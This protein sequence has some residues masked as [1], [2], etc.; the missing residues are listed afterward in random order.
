MGKQK[1]ETNGMK[2]LSTLDELRFHFLGSQN[3][4]IFRAMQI[5]S[6]EMGAGGHL[7]VPI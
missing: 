1:S 5:D 6:H 2:P 7:F 3:D 4:S